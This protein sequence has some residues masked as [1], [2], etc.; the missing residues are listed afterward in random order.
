MVAE[1]HYI[2]L[3]K[4]LSIDLLYLQGLAGKKRGPGSPPGFGSAL[5]AYGLGL[6]GKCRGP[7]PPFW[8]CPGNPGRVCAA[9]VTLMRFGPALAAYGLGLFG[10]LGFICFFVLW[11]WQPAEVW[12]GPGSPPWLGPF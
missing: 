8:K 4:F 10:K 3:S 5:A 11:P 12:V 6:F 7:R 9:Q 2:L 1:L